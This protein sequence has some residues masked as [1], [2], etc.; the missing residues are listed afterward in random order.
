MSKISNYFIFTIVA[1]IF[2]PF[3]ALAQNSVNP[4]KSQPVVKQN[5]QSPVKADEDILRSAVITPREIN[6]GAINS[7]ESKDGIFI[8]KNK[9]AGAVDWST[10]VPE[11]W[12]ASENQKL[13]SVVKSHATDSLR[14]EIQLLSGKSLL[15]DNTSPDALHTVEMKLETGSGKIVCQKEFST[16]IHKEAIKITSA[17]ESKTIFFT[18]I[19]TSTQKSPLINLNPVRLDMGSIPPEKTVSKKIMV[20]NSGKEMLTWS[21]AVQKHEEKDTTANTRK[22]R[23]IS[24]VNEEAR[25]SGAYTSIPEHL[26][27]TME[28]AGKWKEI[29]GY[30]SGA[31]EEN[32]IKINFSGTGII[33][34]LLTYP[35][36][37]DLS[38]NLD[39]NL[40]DDSKLFNGMK[41]KK[42]EILIAE[43]LT[44]GPHVLA[45]ISKDNLLAF[46][47]AKIL[48]K[49]ITYFPAGTITIMPNSGATTSQTNY[50]KVTL[51]SGQMTPGYYADNIV[52]YTNGGE[53]IVE[54]FAEIIPD[55]TSKIV[56][57]YRYYNGTDYLFTANPQA[58]TKRLVQNSYAKEGIAFRLFRPDTP[59]TTSFYRW[60]NPQ[61]R[62][63]F[64]H[65]NITGGGKDLQG[66]I[67]EGS[68]GNIATSRLTNTRELYRWYNSKTDHHFYSTDPQGGK[69][70]KKRYQFE[71]IAGY[72][73]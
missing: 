31:E 64:Y 42:G 69:I 67:F 25:G 66:Y 45:I 37:V 38:V 2:Y 58:E 65:Y 63:H 73:K 10:N 35:D 59:G 18:F 46:E 5:M 12:R 48:G 52:F 21:V 54:I 26:K 49:N 8:F 30:P 51:N 7:G 57:I 41:D 71:G 6:L 22:G 11:G 4:E 34:C 40:I 47:G 36:E 55:N 16:G 9:G 17:G 61:K 44:D 70:N 27:E 15:N 43:G 68:I 29:N 3:I 50:I 14:I 1:L 20:T 19:I 60:Y 24:F 33:L 32:F 56:D 53:G 23:Y 13:S 62:A 72:V 28:L 39:G